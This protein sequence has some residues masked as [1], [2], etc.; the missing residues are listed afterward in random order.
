MYISHDDW[1]QA[2]GTTRTASRSGTAGRG[3]GSPPLRHAPISRS[4]EHCKVRLQD[5]SLEFMPSDDSL[6][7]NENLKLLK[8]IKIQK[9]SVSFAMYVLIMPNDTGYQETINVRNVGD[10]LVICRIEYCRF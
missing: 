2:G 10:L 7:L 3:A 9:K 6:C 8:L 4:G 5:A 1:N